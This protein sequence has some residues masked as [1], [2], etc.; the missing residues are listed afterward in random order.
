MRVSLNIN[1]GFRNFCAQ[2]QTRA[3]FNPALNLAH[4]NGDT[5]TFSGTTKPKIKPET[6]PEV[7]PVAKP[8]A[9]VKKCSYGRIDELLFKI[10]NNTP[11]NEVS[12]QIKHA[13]QTILSAEEKNIGLIAQGIKAKVDNETETV[14]QLYG[15]TAPKKGLHKIEER[16]T[17]GYITRKIVFENG[18]LFLIESEGP[19]FTK[20]I[21]M[22][23]KGQLERYIEGYSKL[24]DGTVTTETEISYWPSGNV[25]HYAKNHS[26]KD[27]TETVEKDSFYDPDGKIGL[28]REHCRLEHYSP[29]SMGKY[30]H[31]GRG[32]LKY[33][34]N[35]GMGINNPT[36]EA[37]VK[38]LRGKPVQLEL[39]G[40][41]YLK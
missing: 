31:R 3:Q 35:Y 20:N 33:V 37:E 1:T 22:F 29:T 27:L 25:M 12:G 32:E 14:K 5:V 26:Q 15:K 6:K 16:A 30:I 24:E 18:S 38:F 39:N 41:S 7:R 28:Y 4:Q 34:K 13:L 17:N 40:I 21:A 8:A 36:A 11:S 19:Y 23:E 10:Q 9:S 2:T